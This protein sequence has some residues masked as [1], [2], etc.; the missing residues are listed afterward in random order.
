M[1]AASDESLASPGP[2]TLLAAGLDLLAV[3]AFALAGRRSHSE[4]LTVEGWWQTAWPFLAGLGLGWLLVVSTSSTWPTRLWHGVWVW[5][6]AVFG[7]MALREMVGQGTATPFVVV[8][9]LVVGVLLLGWRGVAELLDRRR[10]RATPPSRRPR[11]E[12]S[13]TEVG[14]PLGLDDLGEPR[15]TRKGRGV[16]PAEDRERY[17]EEMLDDPRAGGGAGLRDD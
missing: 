10:E 14:D 11:P 17:A 15:S 7:G 3:S 13:H 2:R 1:R 5:L 6:A 16:V 12:V 9:T 4:A 8:A